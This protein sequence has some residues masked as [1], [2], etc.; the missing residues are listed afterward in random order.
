MMRM[1][2]IF[3]HTGHQGGH[4]RGGIMR[5]N[6]CRW[7]KILPS[8]TSLAV[9]SWKPCRIEAELPPYIEVISE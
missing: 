2:R 5:V 4:Q 6:Q 3:A 8:I 9:D 7:I 1:K